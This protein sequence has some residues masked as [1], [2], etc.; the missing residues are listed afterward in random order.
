MQA[1]AQ[2]NC[3]SSDFL[4]HLHHFSTDL[5]NSDSDGPGFLPVKL[6]VETQLEK[7]KQKLHVM[8][9]NHRK[10]ANTEDVC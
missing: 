8:S 3:H 6:H 5:T 4:A 7:T 9:I 1:I 10:H 2:N